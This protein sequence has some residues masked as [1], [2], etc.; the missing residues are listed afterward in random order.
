MNDYAKKIKTERPFSK[1][2]VLIVLIV[3][4]LCLLPIV[5]LFF[6]SEGDTVSITYDGKTT[7]YSL[8]QNATIPLK[9]GKIIVKIDSGSVKVVTNDC[10]NGICMHGAPISEVGE[11]IVCIPNSLV[12]K[13]I[14]EGFNASTGGGL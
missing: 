7:N 14:G 10:E 9:D 1:V 4:I 13:I 11:S 12:V 6:R 3:L 2:D 5:S 8:S